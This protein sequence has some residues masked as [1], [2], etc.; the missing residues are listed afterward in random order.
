MYMEEW[1]CSKI[2]SQLPGF[3]A[4][5]S[6]IP[7]CSVKR[8]HLAEKPDATD[9]R[10]FQVADLVCTLDHIKAKI[11]IGIF[12]NSERDFFSNKQSFRKD[13]W[14]KLNKQRMN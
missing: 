3:P 12:S 7:T 2:G 9:Y 11:D 5:V 8:I 14:R 6:S 1:R 4:L 13:F 10:L